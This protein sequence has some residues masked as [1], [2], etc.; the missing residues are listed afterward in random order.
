[1]PRSDRRRAIRLVGGGRPSRYRGAALVA[2]A[3]VVLL[4]AL[5]VPVG[6]AGAGSGRV[7]AR[8][9][10]TYVRVDQS[11]YPDTAE[12]VAF[13]MSTRAQSGSAVVADS[14]G[15]TVDSVPVGP[16]VGKWNSTFKYVYKVEFTSVT[17]DGVYTVSAGGATSPPFPIGAASEVY[18]EDLANSLSFYQDERD[19][20]DFIPSALRTAPAHLN[21][22][23][24]TV[25]ETPTVNANGNFK[26]NLT[27]LGQ[28]IDAAGGWWDAGDYLKFVE[29]TS[30]VV[31]LM[32]DGV[33][34]FPAEMGPG[35]ADA[36]F[37]D[38]AEF[39]LN[40]LMEM[41]N[42][43]SETL[44]YQVGI[45]AGNT[46]GTILSD[47]DI[48]R[49]PQ[50]DDTYG[51]TDPTFQYI[52]N[53]PVFEA[54]PAG[55]PIS[56]NLAGR[57]AADFGLCYQVF[58]LSNPSLADS[59]LLDGETVFGLAK[60]TDVGQL[61]TTIP[62]DFYPETNWQDDLEYGATELYLA[63]ADGGSSVPGLPET[64]APYYLDQ[65]ADWAQA[66]ISI[67]PSRYD[68]LNLY[69]V[70]GLAHYDLY[71]AITQAGD[72]PGLAVTPAQLL[73]NLGTLVGIGVTQ[74]AGTPFGYGAAWNQADSVSRGDGLSVMA[75]EYDDL[76]QST[77]YAAQAQGWLDGA[78][79]SNP[80]GVSFIVGDGSTFPGCLS[81]QVANL[82]GSLTGGSPVLD[83]AAVEGPAASGTRGLLPGMKACSVDYR[84]FD[85]KYGDFVDDEQSYDTTEPAIDLTA[86]SFL[87][88]SWLSTTGQ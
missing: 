47:H 34:T 36:N 79:G 71:R 32:L 3:A 83:G 70:A 27:S 40:W 73:T 15:A 28:T 87:A 41:W 9:A 67:G 46:S 33:E 13:V 18:A 16:S 17:A 7:D 2:T 82:S 78:L 55:S 59:C 85:S 68:T 65:A 72:P 10:T 84:K 54:G 64:S 45:G 52:R 21:D 80:W 30:Y 6:A 26:G 14:A 75:S 19:G 42:Q 5:V 39:G 74:A 20:P 31:A 8:A 44:Y 62:Y 63:L 56:P 88:L 61:L 69:D 11:G 37:T 12:K 29:T 77:T 22:G 53:R 25:Y 48:W 86:S 81:H 76:T 23:H 50:V 57:L 66:Y 4:V 49:L 60:T 38:E 1:V 35:S 43:Q 51:G 24:A 58:H